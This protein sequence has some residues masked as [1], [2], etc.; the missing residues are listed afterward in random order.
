MFL[1]CFPLVVH[2]PTGL[3]L[4]PTDDELLPERRHDLIRA[5]SPCQGG[6]PNGGDLYYTYSVGMP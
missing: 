5:F 6:D 2:P 3:C 4:C 1:R